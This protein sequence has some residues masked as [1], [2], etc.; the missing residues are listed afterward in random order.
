MIG[1]GAVGSALGYWLRQIGLDGHW[2]I[3]DGDRYVVHNTSRTIGATPADAGW[4]DGEGSNK[5]V[6][7]GRAIAIVIPVVVVDG[8]LYTLTY[9]RSGEERLELAGS[10]RV[11]WHGAA[12]AKPLLVHVVT[13]A[14]LRTW[15]T[16]IKHATQDVATLLRPHDLPPKVMIG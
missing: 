3:A 2:T 11:V 5:A 12:D 6:V 10:S 13:R 1:A 16:T 15:A 8:P 14:E 9:A 4:P 7:A